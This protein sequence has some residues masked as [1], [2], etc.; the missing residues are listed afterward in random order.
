M[1]INKVILILL[2]MFSIEMFSQPLTITINGGMYNAVSPPENTFSCGGGSSVGPGDLIEII[3]DYG[4][5]KIVVEPYIGIGY[6]IPYPPL[7]DGLRL[8][9]PTLNEAGEYIDLGIKKTYEVGKMDLRLFAGLGYRWDSYLAE[10]NDYN[11]SQTFHFK[12]LK[13][14]TGIQMNFGFLDNIDVTLSYEYTIK[15]KVESK[16]TKNRMRYEFTGGGN[17]HSL[18]LGLS[19]NIS[20]ML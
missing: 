18:L 16:G 3:I 9:Y 1:V 14:Q 10:Y 20:E 19:F 17:S 12:G 11:Y 5:K 4:K 2:F 13:Y 6:K 15:E 7:K 8:D